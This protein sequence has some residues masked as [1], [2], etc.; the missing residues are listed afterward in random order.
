MKFTLGW[1]KQHLET[2]A[3]LE[4]ICDKLTA[5][6]LEVEKVED[7]GKTLAPF[8]IAHVLTAEKHPNADRLKVTTVDTGKEKL[9]VVCGA[10][11]C[12]PGIRTVYVPLGI[13]IVSGIESDGML[14]SAAELGITRDN[15][16]I[17]ELRG[18]Q[19]K[20]SVRFFFSDSE[21]FLPFGGG[22]LQE[23][24]GST[25]A[26]SVRP[27]NRPAD[28]LPWLSLYKKQLA[29][30]LPMIMPTSTETRCVRS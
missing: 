21:S 7:R 26:S 12:R 20:L 22:D 15:A 8:I 27:T 5:I 10:P 25:L 18:G 4:Q 24:L 13:K 3:T 17:I 23:S 30:K 2:T 14:A 1:L 19:D 29:N 6:G 9:Q 16:G 11:N 28:T